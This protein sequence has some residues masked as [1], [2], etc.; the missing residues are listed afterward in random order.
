MEVCEQ[1][2]AD[3]QFLRNRDRC[4]ADEEFGHRVQAKRRPREAI[5]IPSR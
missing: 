4:T 2:V 1:P 5:A 3:E